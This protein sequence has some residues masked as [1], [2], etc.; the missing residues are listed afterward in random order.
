MSERNSRDRRRNAVPA[1]RKPRRA[2]AT[3]P[4]ADAPDSNA[5][6]DRDSGLNLVSTRKALGPDI[7]EGQAP[8]PAQT[9][10]VQWSG[11]RRELFHALY[12]THFDFV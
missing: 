12:R 5:P 1:H 8:Q 4:V 6:L 9:Q 11:A 3:Q 7:T 2:A 10:Q